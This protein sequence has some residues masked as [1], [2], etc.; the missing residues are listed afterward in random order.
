MKTAIIICGQP[1]FVEECFPL[2]NENLIGP[3]SPD[4][5]A[6]LW[7]SEEMCD[8]PYKYGG[9]G[10]WKNQRIKKDSIEKFSELYNPTLL[11]VEKPKTF[12][13]S[14]I[15]FEESLKKYFYGAIDNKEEPDFRF[16][17]IRDNY[18]AKYSLLKSNM[19]KKT[20]ELENDF[21]YDYVI[22]L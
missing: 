15:N 3:N 22:K 19:L 11:E 9:A 10:Q 13:N 16:R 5:F 7:F 20:Y 12:L 14:N 21:K 18:S 17:T 1:R 2:I 8:E 4:V 6:H